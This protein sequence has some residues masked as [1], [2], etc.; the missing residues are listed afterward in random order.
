MTIP[1]ERNRR[2]ILK[3]VSWRVLGS[4]DTFVLSAFITGS[5]RLASSIAVVEVLTKTVLYY[6][7]ERVWLRIP[8]AGDDGP[9]LAP[10]GL[11]GR[12]SK[13]L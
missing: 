12:W 6:G 10:N 1:A 7:H 11:A 9:E 13:T 4:V 3:A 2:S 5:F 8:G